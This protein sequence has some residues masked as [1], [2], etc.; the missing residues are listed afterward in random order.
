MVRFVWIFVNDINVILEFVVIDLKGDF[1]V[2]L[3]VINMCKCEN[4]GECDFMEFVGDNSGVFCVVGCN[5]SD[6]YEGMFCENE[7]FDVCVDD[8]CFDNVI[9]NIIR[10]LFG[11]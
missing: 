5:C 11:F 9:C 8:L 7:I 1:L 2:F 4:D 10:N 3:V 6:G